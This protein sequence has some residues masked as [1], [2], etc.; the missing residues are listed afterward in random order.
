MEQLQQSLQENI[1]SLICFNEKALPVIANNITIEMFESSIY[2]E[3]AR[4]ALNYYKEFSVPVAD[5]LPDVLDHVLNGTDEGKAKLFE[6]IILNLYETKDSVHVE[7]VLSK[8]QAFL[9]QQS[10]KLAVKEAG[11]CLLVGKV[12]EAENIL[13]KNRHKQIKAF[14]TGTKITDFSR[15]LRFSAE[16]DNGINTGIVELDKLGHVPNPKELYVIVGLPGKGKSWF[17]TTIGKH[18]L[19]QRKKVLEVT[20]EMSEQK[21]AMRYF[22]AMFGIGKTKEKVNK[23]FATFQ[24]DH[25]GCVSQID[26]NTLKRDVLTV[27]DPDFDDK[28]KALMNRHTIPEMII[29]E[30]PTATLTVEGLRAYM[31]NLHSFHG[32]VPDILLIDYPDLMFVNNDRLRTDTGAIYKDLRG[33]AME[34]GIPVVA[35][36]QANRSGEDVKIL[37]RKHLAEDFSKVQTADVLVTYNQTSAEKE[38][39]LARLYVDKGR[40][41]R[42]GD[43]ILISQNY[44]IGQFCLDSTLMTKEYWKIIKTITGDKE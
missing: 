28:V 21:K 26:F 24:K 18:A 15:S 19:L 14:D 2:R 37:T 27:D 43:T 41:D 8:L 33:I 20:L 44:S 25:Y 36:S 9:R 3:I 22:Q 38:L 13:S 40:N 4:Q 7:Y 10:L 42:D 35:P 29:K 30:F 39:G 5:H 31:E 17:L 12:D 1:L 16:Q 11:E 32:F 34:W 23:V 6:K